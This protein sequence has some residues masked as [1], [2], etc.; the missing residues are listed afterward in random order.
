MCIFSSPSHWAGIRELFPNDYYAFCEVERQLGFTLD[1][2]RD[3]ETFVGSAKSCVSHDN[4]TAI[5]QLIT[6]GFECSD[7]YT[8]SIR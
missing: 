3:L 6:G 8:P 1:A 2:K 5:K 4:P 7:I